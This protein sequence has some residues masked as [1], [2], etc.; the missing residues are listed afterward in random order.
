VPPDALADD[1]A[2][3]AL[4]R[5][6]PDPPGRGHSRGDGSH[7]AMTRPHLGDRRPTAAPIAGG[8]GPPRLGLSRWSRCLTVPAPAVTNVAP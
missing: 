7:Y 3:V 4:R 6:G 5:E 2:M 8:Y 1:M